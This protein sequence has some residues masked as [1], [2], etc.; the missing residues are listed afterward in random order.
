[1]RGRRGSS[2]SL[3]LVE[4]FPAQNPTLQVEWEYVC[5]FDDQGGMRYK[6]LV[7]LIGLV[8]VSS[9][10]LEA[11]QTKKDN[12]PPPPPVRKT[13]FQDNPAPPEARPIQLKEIPD[14][15]PV[16]QGDGPSADLAIADGAF[17]IRLSY[18]EGERWRDMGVATLFVEDQAFEVTSVQGVDDHLWRFDQS[19]LSA[20]ARAALADGAQVRVRLSLV[21]SRFRASRAIRLYDVDTPPITWRAL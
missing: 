9:W 18:P 10:A 17:E 16:M 7:I 4:C 1:M 21:D 5:S 14:R 20:E 6:D 2:R 15:P 19:D 11:Q 3:V 12:P 13:Y 8:A